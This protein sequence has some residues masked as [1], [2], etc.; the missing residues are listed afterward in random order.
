[1]PRITLTKASEALRGAADAA[2]RLER[3]WAKIC[4]DASVPFVKQ[5]QQGQPNR[6]KRG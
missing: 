3:S 6:L 1:M 5:A 2:L 4:G